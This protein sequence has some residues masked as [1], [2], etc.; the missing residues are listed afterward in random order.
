MKPALFKIKT[1]CEKE[2]EVEAITHSQAITIWSNTKPKGEF[3]KSCSRI[4]SSKDVDRYLELK[5]MES[6]S[7]HEENELKLLVDTFKNSDI[8]KQY[9][10]Y[11]SFKMI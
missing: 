4:R 1:M 2:Y 8:F 10:K 3:F 7:K 6:R 5:G 9:K 11:N